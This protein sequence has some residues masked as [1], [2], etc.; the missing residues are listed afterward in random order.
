M[1]RGF[2]PCGRVTYRGLRAR[3][4]RQSGLAAGGRVG[5]EVGLP[6]KRDSPI[7][8]RPWAWR[9]GKYDGGEKDDMAAEPEPD[10]VVAHLYGLS[11]SHLT[12]VLE[13][14]DQGW[15]HQ[16]HLKVILKPKRRGVA[17][18]GRS[19][20]VRQEQRTLGD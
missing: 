7:G 13:T 16:P 12:Q 2:E 9:Y 15:A 5:G 14:F 3:R 10:A 1:D 8:L 19:R 18:L 20:I 4:P 17:R 6:G 11:E